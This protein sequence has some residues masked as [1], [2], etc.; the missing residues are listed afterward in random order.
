MLLFVAAATIATF[1]AELIAAKQFD[2]APK[3]AA[4]MASTKSRFTEC[5]VTTHLPL[6]SSLEFASSIFALL[7]LTSRLPLPRF[8]GDMQPV[9]SV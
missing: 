9:P 4:E 1:G 8:S 7:R 2:Q 5:L 3:V 6:D